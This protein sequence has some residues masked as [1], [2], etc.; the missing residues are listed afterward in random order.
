MYERFT[1]RARTVMQ[2]ADREARRL[3]HEYIGTDHI[4]LGLIAEEAGVAGAV[5]AN[6]GIDL[7]KARRKVEELVPPL[8]PGAQFGELPLTP[9]AAQAI[10]YS[11]EEAAKLSHNY[12]GTEHLIL[13]LTRDADFVA[14]QAL[15]GLGVAL[16]DVREEVLSVLGHNRDGTPMWPRRR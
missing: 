10:A 13:G 3:N 2:L 8:P 4:L 11:H 1:D 9:R 5:L 6:L 16:E 7:P 15:V 12:V 14:A